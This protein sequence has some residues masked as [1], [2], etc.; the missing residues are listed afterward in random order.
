[1]P[2]QDNM[3]MPKQDNMAPMMMTPTQETIKKI[4]GN[5]AMEV[6]DAAYRLAAKLLAE[7]VLNRITTQLGPQ[8]AVSTFLTLKGVPGEAIVSFVL[9]AILELVPTNSLMET[10]ARLACN[11]R[12]QSYFDVGELLLK[13]SGMVQLFTGALEEEVEKAIRLAGVQP[14]PI[15][16][17]APKPNGAA[18]AGDGAETAAPAAPRTY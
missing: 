13:S 11:L 10:K 16:K 9:A 5:V 4:T 17:P 18:G 15:G 12:V 2:T 1:M 6:P 8:H 7:G 3:T 14:N